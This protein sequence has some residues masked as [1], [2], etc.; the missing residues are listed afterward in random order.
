MSIAINKTNCI[1]CRKCLTVCPGSLIKM[2]ADQKAY[3]KYPEDCWGC[4]SCLKECGQSAISL[5]LG[6][7]IGGMGS[8]LS[9]SIEGDIIHWQIVKYDGEIVTIDVNRKDSNQY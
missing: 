6:A 1:G 5:Y 3:I 8:R 4:S 2:G 9:T 7:D